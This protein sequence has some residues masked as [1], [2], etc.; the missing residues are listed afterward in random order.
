MTM[1]VWEV[2]SILGGGR[3]QFI[4]LV[5]RRLAPHWYDHH[6]V[7]LAALWATVGSTDAW[8]EA[9]A[10]WEI[11]DWAAYAAALG[12]PAT[13][14]LLNEAYQFR[15]GGEQLLLEPAGL[16]TNAPLDQ[17]AYLAE[18]IVVAPGMLDTYYDLLQQVYLPLAKARGMQ[19]A[20]AYRLPLR[21]NEGLNLW[22]CQDFYHWAALMNSQ[23]DYPGRETWE[24][25]IAT[26]LRRSR[27]KLLAVPPA[28]T[29]RT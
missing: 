25:A 2:A 26:I 6:G 9:I 10:L 17:G 4:E 23:F 27:M 3:G 28:R 20:G 18:R 22:Q 8:P 14:E 24:A 11:R 15:S 21:A 1:F 13:E 7:R 5:R 12:D 19:L 16:P 29:L